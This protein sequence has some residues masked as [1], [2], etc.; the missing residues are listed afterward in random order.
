MFD[1]IAGDSIDARGRVNLLDAVDAAQI[2]RADLAGCGP[3]IGADRAK[4]E[5]AAG[6]HAE[7]AA[8]DALLSHAQPNQR[9][10]VALRLQKLHHGHVVGYRGSGSDDF[11]EICLDLLHFFQ[12]LFK[13]AWGADYLDRL[14]D[15][16]P[17]TNAPKLS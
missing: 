13:I 6:S 11:V 4:G 5:N 10:L 14:H 12:R 1:G 9:M 17:A 16:R 2:L 8:D 15:S 3:E 7:H